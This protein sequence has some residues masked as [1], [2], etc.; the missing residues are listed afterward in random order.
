[1][2]TRLRRR[3]K[4]CMERNI[5]SLFSAGYLI[6]SF[7]EEIK[8]ESL[9]MKYFVLKPRSNSIDDPYAHASRMAMLAYAKY[10]KKINADL[11]NELIKW[12]DREVDK[13]IKFINNEN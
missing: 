10:I 7:L 13:T 1:M 5:T 3:K 6:V 9:F 8:M 12:A 4:T 11:A 2:G